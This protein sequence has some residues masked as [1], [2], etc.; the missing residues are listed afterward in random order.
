MWGSGKKITFENYEKYLDGISVRSLAL[1]E[2]IS[3][4]GWVLTRRRNV[5]QGKGSG[6]RRRGKE[7]MEMS[8][9]SSSLSEMMTWPLKQTGIFVYHLQGGSAKEEKLN[10]ACLVGVWW[11]GDGGRKEPPEKSTDHQGFPWRLQISERFPLRIGP[12]LSNPNL[13]SWKS[14]ALPIWGSIH[15][16]GAPRQESP[17]KPHLFFL[18]FPSKYFYP[19]YFFFFLL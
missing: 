8:Q 4:K 9:K 13:N 12:G 19:S 1:L 3:G 17:K 14:L 6:A 5:G 18:G 16:T 7:T 10:R 11:C 2:E 15:S